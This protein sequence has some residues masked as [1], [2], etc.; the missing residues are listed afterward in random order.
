[1]RIEFFQQACILDTSIAN[2]FRITT[3]FL[4]VAS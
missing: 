4:K 2:T 1:M 3:N